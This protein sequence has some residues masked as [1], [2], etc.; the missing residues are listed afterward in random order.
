MIALFRVDNRLIHGQVVEAWLPSVGAQRLLVADDEAAANPLIRAAMALAVPPTVKVQIAP[1][2]SADFASALSGP[3]RTV[4]LVRDVGGAVVA[5]ERGLAFTALNLGNIHFESGRIQISPS[6]FLSPAEAKSL[7]ALAG[8]G[9]AVEARALP[10][11]KPL[12]LSEIVA[13][14][15]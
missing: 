12:P 8:S 14:V 1:L 5:R 15:L 10:K 4:V 11:D 3:E 13:K 7:Q 9:V 2:A 6:V